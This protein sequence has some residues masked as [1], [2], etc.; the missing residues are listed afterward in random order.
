MRQSTQSGERRGVSPPCI[1]SHGGLTPRRSLGFTLIELLVVMALF[2]ALATLAI[3]VVPQAMDSQRGSQGGVRLQ[4][5]L[6]TAQQRAVLDRAPRGL[7]LLPDPSGSGLVSQVQY[8]EQPDDFTGGTVVTPMSNGQPQL[9]ALQFTVDLTGGQPNDS[10]LWPVQPGDYVEVMGSG[11]MH[12]ISQP[13][14]TLPSGGVVPPYVYMDSPLPQ[15]IT[16]ATTQYRIVR[17]ARVLGDEPMEMPSNV[18]INLNTNGQYGNPVP[19]G[20][21]GAVDILFSP[22]GEVLSNTG[23]PRI[24]LWVHDTTLGSP[25]LGSPTLIVVYP[26]SGQIA[27]Y[28]VNTDPNYAGG[29]P[30]AFVP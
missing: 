19:P 24:I 30:Y 29:N 14:R 5:W 27:A 13:S 9:N 16:T 18:A 22:K 26:R 23:N 3:L 2:I 28:D 17:A 6:M 21:N 8:I 25:A 12:I 7:R 15:A 10:T 1:C 11:L 20:P 4:G